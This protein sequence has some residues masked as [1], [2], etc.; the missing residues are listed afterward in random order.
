MARPQASSGFP[1]RAPVRLRPR[2][3]VRVGSAGSSWRR[4][5]SRSRFRSSSSSSTRPTPR[6]PV[7]VPQSDRLLPAGP[8]QPQVIAFQGA[9]RLFLP[10]S[11]SRVTAVGYQRVG[12]GA[13]ALDPVGTQAN[14]GVFTRL[15]R[16]LVGEDQPGIRYYL[17][18]GTAGPET[19][20]LDV[21]AAAGTDVYAPVDGT[22]IAISD[23][24]LSGRPYGVRIDLQP[25]GSPGLVVS[26]TNL[27]PR[28]GADGRLDRRRGADEG[29]HR[30]GLVP[31]RV[32]CA[33]PLHAG[34][35]TARPDRG[36]ARVQPQPALSSGLRILLVADVFGAP[37]RRAVE[38]A[39]AHPPARPRRR[40]LRR[41]RGERRRRRRPDG[42]ARPPAPRRRGRR[43]HD[44]ESRVAAPRPDSRSRELRARASPGEPGRLGTPGRGTTVIPARDGTPVAVINLDGPAVHGR[45]DTPVPGRRASSSMKARRATRRS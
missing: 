7:P 45:A 38:D 28:R 33:R 8:P 22:V 5:R 37:G 27:R 35:G 29:R 36:S 21:G 12:D 40:S 14:A 43:D 25:S 39:A 11:E 2:G 44:R 42:E 24:I 20:G 30:R 4:S 19:G 26:M 15:L 13:L 9:L 6:R 18:G 41:Q 23:H 31:G 17:L 34:L 3:R 10:I 32:V 1:A 16:R